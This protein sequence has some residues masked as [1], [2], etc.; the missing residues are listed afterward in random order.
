[1][2]SALPACPLL[3]LITCGCFYNFPLEQKTACPVS[4]E[5]AEGFAC[6]GGECVDSSRATCVPFDRRCV[7]QV[8]WTCA[9]D[10]SSEQGVDCAATS[11]V[12]ASGACLTPC[13]AGCKT[14]EACDPNAKACVAQLGCTTA[15]DCKGAPNQGCF[16]GVCVP[17]PSQPTPEGLLS[18]YPQQNPIGYAFAGSVRG[19]SSSD[20]LPARGTLLVADGQDFDAYD[21]TFTT[22]TQIP[23]GTMLLLRFASDH[24]IAPGQHVG[25]QLGTA[26][27]T[28]S[29]LALTGT[30]RDSLLASEAPADASGPTWDMHGRGLVVGQVRDCTGA[31][32]GGATVGFSV[33]VG[34]PGYLGKANQSPPQLW[35]QGAT[36]TVAGIGTFVAYD[37]PVGVDFDVVAVAL[38]QDTLGGTSPVVIWQQRVSIDAPAASGYGVTT[39]DVGRGGR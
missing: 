12:C 36:S 31:W 23:S 37:V 32:L 5:C 1:V 29:L 16:G 18:C 9:A 13:S 11:R 21:G 33:P 34:R 4:G 22:T 15:A 38:K 28:L 6:L 20:P 39:L 27:E 3:L 8:A 26:S 2:S 35:R 25:P 30:Q 17:V 10:G 14:G 24:G 7:G 19:L